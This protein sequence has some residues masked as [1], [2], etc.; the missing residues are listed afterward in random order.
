MGN[1]LL[2]GAAKMG[3]DIRLIAPKAYWP[4]KELVETSQHIAKQTGANITLTENV[5]QGVKGCDFL[6]TDVWLSMGE[7]P[8]AWDERVAQL[9]S[10]QVNMNTIEKTGNPDVKFMHCLPAFHND[11]TIICKEVA[12]KYGMSGLEVTEEVF[13]S[14]HSIVFDEA[15]NRMHTIK[16]V[17]VATLGD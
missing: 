5:E 14:R 2:V 10:Y 13:E 6:Y 1:S 11:E 7:D 8:E 9:R 12:E 17:M 3:M 15:E 16:A 4:K